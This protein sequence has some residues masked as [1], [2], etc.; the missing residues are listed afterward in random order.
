MPGQIN[1]VFPC[2]DNHIR[3]ITTDIFQS[4]PKSAG[5]S[6]ICDIEASDQPVLAMAK[7]SG[8]QLSLSISNPDPN[9]TGSAPLFGANQVMPITITLKGK[10]SLDLALSEVSSIAIVGDN[11]VFTINTTDGEAY[12]MSLTQVN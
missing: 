12:D 8:S 1:L 2:A 10:W 5:I 9:F 3:R 4:I 6:F 11:T 7:L